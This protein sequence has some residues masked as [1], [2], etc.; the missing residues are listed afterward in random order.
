MLWKF[1]PTDVF[2]AGPADPVPHEVT[3]RQFKQGLSRLN[4]RP[5]V[6]AWIPTQSQDVIDWYTDS[7]SV[8]RSNSILLAA[9]NHFGLSDAQV[10]A[11]FV[12]MSGL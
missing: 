5:A 3:L 7:N 6:E 12:M 9:A 4:L 8:Q 11:A 10:D 1:A 2:P